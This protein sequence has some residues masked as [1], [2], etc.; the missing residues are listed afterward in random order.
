[1]CFLAHDVFTHVLCF[2]CLLN[3]VSSYKNQPR[4]CVLLLWF[5]LS[6]TAQLV[7]CCTDSLFQYWLT[8]APNMAGIRALGV[9]SRLTLRR[10][11]VITGGN[12]MIFTSEKLEKASE[13]NN[14]ENADICY[15]FGSRNVSWL[16]FILYV[17]ITAIRKCVLAQHTKRTFY[18]SSTYIY[19]YI[20][21][22]LTSIFFKSGSLSS[23]MT[24][25][26]SWLLH[27]QRRYPKV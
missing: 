27:I 8:S 15:M 7:S 20:N 14:T 22:C 9:L 26:A 23:Q 16:T 4:S 17:K 25:L 6:V 5:F 10:Y 2:V 1:M 12:D 11:S 24:V 21:E 19:L 3:K 13:E 18:M